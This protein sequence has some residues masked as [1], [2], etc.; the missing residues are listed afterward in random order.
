VFIFLKTPLGELTALPQTPYLDLR[1]PTSKG[2]GGEGRGGEGRRGKRRERGGERNKNPPSDR[3]GYW[4]ALTVTEMWNKVY[5]FCIYFSEDV[6]SAPI[7]S[8]LWRLLK[9]FLFQQSYPDI[10]I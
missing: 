10:V 8:S 3:S 1:G 2:K 5:E 4:P 6:V 9:L 7:F